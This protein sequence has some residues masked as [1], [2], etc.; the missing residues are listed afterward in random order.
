MRLKP[1]TLSAEPELFEQVIEKLDK[2]AVEQET[3][4]SAILRG[5]IYD[6]FGIENDKRIKPLNC[7]RSIKS[8]KA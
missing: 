6:H 8:R 3:N 2:I 7:A 1:Y 5:I 4:R